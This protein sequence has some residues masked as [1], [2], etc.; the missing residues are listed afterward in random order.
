MHRIFFILPLLAL[1]AYVAADPLWT[2]DAVVR[3]AQNIV[4]QKTSAPDG[5]GNVISLWT[6]DLEGDNCLVANKFNAMGQALWTE[7]ITIRASV[8]KKEQ[9]QAVANSDGGC[10]CGWIEDFN[11]D[12]FSLRLQKISPEGAL[13][14]A[15]DG[16]LI[17]EVTGNPQQYLIKPNGIGGAALF[18]N[19]QP[20]S[21]GPGFALGYYFDAAGNYAWA[22]D[23]PQI[24]Y[25]GWVDLQGLACSSSEDG[26]VVFYQVLT[27]Q[28]RTNCF[29]RYTASGYN[30]WEQSYPALSGE[31]GPHQILMTEDQVIYDFCKVAW[32]DTRISVHNLYFGSGNWTVAN[33]AEF[34]V[35]PSPV[36]D[37]TLFK[38]SFY[39]NIGQTWVAVSTAQNGTTSIRGYILNPYLEVLA[40][41]EIRSTDAV[42]EHLDSCFDNT[43]KCF[44][45]WTESYDTYGTKSL[46]AQVR[47]NYS[48]EFVWPDT[49]KIICP[50]LDSDAGFAIHAWESGLLAVFVE[51]GQESE[52]LRR[53]AYD[54]AGNPLLP[55]E[56]EACATALSGSAWPYANLN[57]GGCSIMIYTD[58]R[59][60]SHT[61]LYYRQ[62]DD[63]GASMLDPGEVLICSGLSNGLV[64][65]DATTGPGNTFAVLYNDSGV[66]LKT[67]DLSGNALPPE[68]LLLGG[69]S[70]NLYT[71][72]RLS[73]HEGDYYA[74]WME[75]IGTATGVRGQRVSG[76]QLMWGADGIPLREAVSGGVEG[77]GR[78]AGRYF[79]WTI[80]LGGTRQ[81]RC[82]RLDTAGN[83][84]PGWYPDG[85]L[86]FQV[87]DS[88]LYSPVWAA[89]SGSDLLFCAAGYVS[90]PIYGQKVLPDASLPW[91]MD[92]ILIHDPPHMIK[93]GLVD[94]RGLAVSWLDNANPLPGYYL[95]VLT[96]QGDF[97]YDQPGINLDTE[98]PQ[99]SGYMSLG[100]FDNGNLLAVWSACYQPYSESD[101]LYYRRFSAWGEMLEDAPQLLCAAPRVQNTPYISTP[102]GDNASICWADARAGI[103]N[104]ASPR[105]GVFAQLLNSGSSAL[106]ELPETPYALWL[107]PCSPNPFSASST[108]RWTQKDSAPALCSVY[109]LKGQL[110]KRFPSTAARAGE[111]QIVW[112]GDDDQGRTVASGIY[113]IRLQSGDQTRTRK[114]LRW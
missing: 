1:C 2:S 68:G 8:E 63:S 97:V 49:G 33:G 61:R 88:N 54:F 106:P 23:R 78:P 19:P 107:A 84:E 75:R 99:H 65:L 29:R 73:C 43:F 48:G 11:G 90:G 66:R 81:I 103:F 80:N 55:P 51:P 70:S 67:F 18:V 83:L 89:L 15:L 87:N 77:V 12:A 40:S 110:V 9:V 50:V 52:S 100:R 36:P 104:Q 114:I 105:Y 47:D 24:Q 109:N 69:Q 3:E 31:A 98:L 25:A 101:D 14:W 46:R 34:V 76:G 57:V 32:T 85:N 7:P 20:W 16:Q 22:S 60:P 39:G 112:N 82:K 71:S 95:Q 72:A 59:D 92:G 79:T 30:L 113:F 37:A 91:T 42:V 26:V 96:P 108:I 94:E 93:A 102:P 10:I 58:T 6:Q 17:S 111:H 38:A 4:C 86:V 41:Q 13:L 44:Y 64:F 27:S 74:A 62:L 35:N 28:S 21:N 53:R 45:A 5:Q 56:A